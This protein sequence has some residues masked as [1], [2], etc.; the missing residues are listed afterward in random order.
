MRHK[1]SVETAIEMLALEAADHISEGLGYKADSVSAEMVAAEIEAFCLAAEHG[2][3]CRDD[4]TMVIDR[5]SSLCVDDEE[6]PVDE[7]VFLDVIKPWT[8]NLRTIAKSLEPG[9]FGLYWAW[10][11]DHDEDWFIVAKSSY[12]AA[13]GH[14][15]AEGY[16]VGDARSYH[17]VNVPEGVKAEDGWPSD[18]LLIACGGEIVRGKQPRVVRFGEKTYTEGALDAEI[19]RIWDDQLEAQGMG[20]PNGTEP[21]GIPS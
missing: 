3:L 12:D 17:V 5:L 16:D 8:K 19:T 18:E 11:V 20:R 21:E 6:D 10:T 9:K 13:R 2:W 14:E 4:A 15:E 7:Q 1:K